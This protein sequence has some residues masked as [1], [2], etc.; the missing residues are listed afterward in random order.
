MGKQVCYYCRKDSS[1]VCC[2]ACEPIVKRVA[3]LR[4]QIE[5]YG[6]GHT[7]R[8]NGMT[9]AGLLEFTARAR[10]PLD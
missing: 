8:I 3:S 2:E 5:V 6:V 4:E 10:G 9:I 7:A 1:T